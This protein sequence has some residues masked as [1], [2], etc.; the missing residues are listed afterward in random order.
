MYKLVPILLFTY[1]LAVTTD[2][3]YDNSYALIIGINDYT[4]TSSPKLKYAVNDA[5]AINGL[6]V[7]K[8]WFKDENI[9]LLLDKEATFSSIRNALYS[10]S[11]LAN[12]NDRVLIYFSGH[13][14]TIKAIQSE[15]QIGYLIPVNG[16]I[17]EPTLNGIPMD[18]IFRIC[19]SKSKHMLFLMDACY[20]GLMAEDPKGLKILENNDV[21]YIVSK[22]N[23]PAR[24]IITAGSA[25]QEVWE[26]DEL[27]HGVFTLNILKALGDWEADYKEED[28]YITATELGEYLKKAVYD[29]SDGRQ[30]PQ[31]ERIKHSK[32]GE[33]VFSK[34]K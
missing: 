27:Q 4:N 12:I 18:D 7:N 5:K 29:E 2:D 11:R 21:E 20:S 17:K 22:A 6:L 24:Q 15:M 26:G 9:Q 14:Q 25:E 28:G 1:G 16:D 30:T 8:F 31:V 3:I 34:F 10:V 32:R 19:Q 13:G 33:F 23:I